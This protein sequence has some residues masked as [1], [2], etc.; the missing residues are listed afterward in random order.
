MNYSSLITDHISKH[1]SAELSANP[2]FINFS[3]F[4]KNTIDSLCHKVEIENKIIE[5]RD[6]M[7]MNSAF[8]SIILFD[9]DGIIKFWN[10]KAEVVFGWKK[11]EVLGKSVYKIVTPERYF[12]KCSECIEEYKKTGK[13]EIMNHLI[14][15]TA[16]NKMKEEFTVE[17]TLV[18]VIQ[19]DKIHFCA[20]VKDITEI[21]N[22]RIFSKKEENKYRNIISNINIGLIEVDNNGMIQ[23]ANEHFTEISGY[24]I[25][26]L[27]GKNPSK[28][29]ISDDNKSI[30][31]FK[32]E[33][34]N[35]GISD[36]YQLKIKNK[37]GEYRWWTISGSPK[38]D[39]IGNIIGSV[40]LHLDVTDQKLLE[41]ELKK[42]KIKAEESAKSKELFLINMSHEIRTPLN[43]II[44]FLRELNREE[45]SDNQKTFVKNSS[46]ASN[47]LL[48]LI[49]NVLDIS[50]I[51]A[52]EIVLENTDFNFKEKISDLVLVLQNK[53]KE[54]NLELNTH[55]SNK[56]HSLL[57]G[58][59]LKIE[60][61]LY[62]IAG[63]SIKFTNKG[64]VSIRFEILED[65]PKH[66]II[67]MTISDTG[68]GMDSDYI[69]K[70]F[71][72]F[73]QENTEIMKQYGGTGLGMSIT[74]ELVRLMNGTITIESKKNIGTSIHITIPILKGNKKSIKKN[75][76]SNTK[77]GNKI[78]LQDISVLLVEDNAINRVV[79]RKSLQNYNCSITEAFS[80][81]QS[82]EF[83]KN[84]KF[85]IILMDIIMPDLDGIETTKIIRDELEITTPIIAFTANAFKS[86]IEKFI[87]IGMNDYVLKPFEETILVK[88]IAKHTIDKVGY[89]KV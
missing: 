15:L 42:A 33:L 10:E 53:A 75:I 71:N 35:K 51:E 1:V 22:A 85:D 40:G 41:I 49:N 84:K 83:L 11:E 4:V 79:A 37:K 81:A 77:N 24:E 68:I 12:L 80:G 5:E 89:T 34:R 69:A 45:L 21:I 82:I 32:K 52:N 64:S 6:K 47:H 86:E 18:P 36:I 43:A 78:N 23:F 28:L 16:I 73:S 61:I 62:N 88:T 54:K 14:E 56:I 29:F 87:E 67:S 9:E 30:V 46:L 2:E 25:E 58:D 44:G 65:F 31:E 19:N 7:I 17:I 70:V 66:Q 3:K 60:Q 13:D 39:E 38:Y 57:K 48:A 50:K 26:E 76:L 55:I 27:M 63:N 74:L 8:N 59:I 20:F 72:K